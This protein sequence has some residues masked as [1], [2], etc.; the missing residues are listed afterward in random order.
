MNN[1]QAKD[2]L[3]AQTA[4]QAALENIPLSDLEK[5]MMY[6]TESDPSY[7]GY[8]GLTAEFEEQYDT[9]AYETKVSRLL[10]NAHARLKKE[11]PEKF[12]EWCQAT[13]V[14]QKGDHYILILLGSGSSSRSH[15]FTYRQLALPVISLALIVITYAA[16]VHHFGPSTGRSKSGR[17]PDQATYVFLPAWLKYLFLSILAGGYF[18]AVILPL[19]LKRQPIELQQYVARLF[20]FSSKK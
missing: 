19:I 2:F 11:N 1:K 5:R 15:S 10:H 8:I 20:S 4:Q 7:D 18:Y 3:V 17:A 16:F 9:A 14:L 12:R 6:F 13:R